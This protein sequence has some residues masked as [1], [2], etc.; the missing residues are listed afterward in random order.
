MSITGSVTC[1]ETILLPLLT[2]LEIIN[3]PA[4]VTLMRA[5]SALQLNSIHTLLF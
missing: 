1:E 5:D 4:T 2:P 3:R